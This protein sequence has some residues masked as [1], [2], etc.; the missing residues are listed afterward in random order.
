MLCCHLQIKLV[1]YIDIELNSDRLRPIVEALI[2]SDPIILGWASI[3][4]TNQRS[5]REGQSVVVPSYQ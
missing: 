1:R 5:C 4:Q 3:Q 2:Q